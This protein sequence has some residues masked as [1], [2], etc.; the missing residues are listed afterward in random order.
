MAAI[1]ITPL[2]SP[3]RKVSYCPIPGI[4][5]WRSILFDQRT[6]LVHIASS[7]AVEQ[8]VNQV[9]LIV[10]GQQIQAV[11]DTLFQQDNAR[12]HVARRTLNDTW[13]KSTCFPHQHPCLIFLPWNTCATSS[14]VSCTDTAGTYHMRATCGHIHCSTQWMWLGKE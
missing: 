4:M 10:D 6:D 12:T 5:V 13:T 1:R 11:F 9:L 2:G 7:L 14:D 8:C 3:Y